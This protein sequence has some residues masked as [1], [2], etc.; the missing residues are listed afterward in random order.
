MRFGEG[1]LCAGLLRRSQSR[2]GT[3]ID[4]MYIC[5]VSPGSPLALSRSIVTV[6]CQ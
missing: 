4:W 1:A 3:E 6:H 5:D 2:R